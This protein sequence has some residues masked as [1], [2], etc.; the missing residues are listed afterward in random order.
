MCRRSEDLLSSLCCVTHGTPLRAP[1]SALPNIS[2]AFATWADALHDGF[3]SHNGL[4]PSSL[5]HGSPASCRSPCRGRARFVNTVLLRIHKLM[6]GSVLHRFIFIGSD[7]FLVV[8]DN[9]EGEGFFY[10][11]RTFGPMQGVFKEVKGKSEGKKI[12]GLLPLGFGQGGS[13][14]ARN[15]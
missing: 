13:N 8:M 5:L 15:G 3:A 9:L 4:T 12:G 7:R 10:P 14:E 2:S 1:L 11:W 6:R